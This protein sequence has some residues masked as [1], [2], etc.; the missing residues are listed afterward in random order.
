[1]INKS[2]IAKKVLVYLGFRKLPCLFHESLIWLI[3]SS[4][5]GL[6]SN[7]EKDVA[8][9]MRQHLLS[10]HWFVDLGAHF[11]LWTLYADRLWN[12]KKP[13]L[14]VEPSPAFETLFKNTSGRKRIS[15]EKKAVSDQI[16]TMKFFSQ[17]TATSGSLVQAIT[18]IN[19]G[20]Q[21][22]V[23]IQED[24]IRCSTLDE[25]TKTFSGRGL[26]KIDCEGHEYK[27]LKGA[28]ENLRKGTAFVVEI[29]PRQLKEEGD[30]PEMVYQLFA[31]HG[32]TVKTLQTRDTTIFT[33]VASLSKK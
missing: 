24:T 32:Y 25:I 31:D 10:A 12:G 29:H 18:K 20:H 21:T 15:I 3:P 11:G 22:G 7:Y 14:A 26:V 16:K 1:M 13:I 23:P 4:W 19:E 17:G 2:Q 5:P 28:F 27:I 9:I 6:R 30:S 8:K 33:I